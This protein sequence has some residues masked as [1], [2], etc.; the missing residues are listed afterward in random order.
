MKILLILYPIKPYMDELIGEEKLPKEKEKIYKFY[1]T[2]IRK[3]YPDFQKVFILFSDKSNLT[4]PDISQL[5]KGFNFQDG[6]IIKASG[7]TFY[8]HYKNHLYPKQSDLLALCPRLMDKLIVGGFHLWDCVNKFAK[9]AYHSGI[10][11]LI[12]EDLTEIFFDLVRKFKN[13]QV[14][15]DK[16]K[17]L[18]LIRKELYKLDHV[19]IERAHKE[20]ANKPWFVQI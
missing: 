13:R 14:P 2:L 8:D 7:I 18:E 11:V 6:D 20:R 16:E 5:P 4:S 19:Y 1:Q 3:R 10:D 15:I 9:Y 12:D 17:S